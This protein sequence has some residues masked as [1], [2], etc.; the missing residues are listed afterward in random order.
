VGYRNGSL[1]KVPH[2]QKDLNIT[3]I[4]TGGKPAA[5]ITWLRNGEP[6]PE[7]MQVFSTVK[8][9]SNKLQDTESVLSITP[10]E[11][12]NEALFT[13]SAKNPALR[14]PLE[15]TIQLSVM[16]ELRGQAVYLVPLSLFPDPPGTPEIEGYQ[17]NQIVKMGDTLMLKC[18][19]PG[20]N[21]LA[22]V[23]WYKNGVDLDF[24]YTSGNGKAENDLSF[25]VQPTDNNAKYRCEAS[26]LV[27]PTPLF[28]EVVLKVHCE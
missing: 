27:T 26:N 3:C 5:E 19:S 22:Q 8:Q 16:R 11:E 12:D 17:N 18:I 10:R 15:T 24:S 28:K 23:Y 7:E 2:E 13:C 21:P 14:R 9:L 6:V 4:S 1:I 20:G 25:T